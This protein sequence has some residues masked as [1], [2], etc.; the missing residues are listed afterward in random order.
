MHLGHAQHPL[1]DLHRRLDVRHRAVVPRPALRL[2]RRREQQACAGKK[3]AR[4]L[5][6]ILVVKMRFPRAPVAQWIEQP[7]PK[8]QVARSIRVRGANSLSI[9][10]PM[11]KSL[12][13][14]VVL[15]AFD[16]SAAERAED[17]WNL[18]DVYPSV[19]AY[20][21]DAARLQAE[22]ESFGACRGHLAES[23]ARLKSCLERYSS[24]SKR[25]GRL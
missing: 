21:E 9:N 16:A 24:V 6:M 12:A 8:G 13:L 5:Q 10:S 17:H 7:P 25:L 19:Q 3:T 4:E 23:A 15:L 22:L 2:R 11:I 14:S 20:R 18:A 1:D